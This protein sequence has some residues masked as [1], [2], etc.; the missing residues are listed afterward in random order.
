LVG[1]YEVKREIAIKSGE[2][3]AE[4]KLP[5][6][7]T[8]AINYFRSLKVIN[9]FEYQLM[10]AQMRR[11][12]FSYARQTDETVLEMVREKIQNYIESGKKIE[13]FTKEID[14][15]FDSLGLTKLNPYHLDNV[16]LTN[17]QNGYSQGREKVID[18]LDI[19]EFPYRQIMTV[20]DNRERPSHTRLDGYVAV[21]ND[22]VWDWLKTPFSYR[23]RCKISP[24]HRD[25]G[26]TPSG[27]IPDVRGK[28]GF[29]FLK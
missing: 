2:S 9:W 21:K 25:E 27:Y 17:A 28:M 8:Q 24:V 15:A 5:D 11:K 22:P 19:E 12:S 20:G 18:D 29:E 7:L 26:L 3:F 13:D 16:F 10:T 4:I 1:R 23:C 14:G 6:I